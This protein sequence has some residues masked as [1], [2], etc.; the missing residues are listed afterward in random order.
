METNIFRHNFF[1]K[2]IIDNVSLGIVFRK[3]GRRFK[4][5]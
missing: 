5:F 1:S 2:T 4:L 3:F